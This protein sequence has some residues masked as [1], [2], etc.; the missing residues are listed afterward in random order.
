MEP[1]VVGV[2]Y[3]VYFALAFAGEGLKS[4]PL[5]LIGTA[6]YFV[7]AIA[8][9]LMLRPVEPAIAWALLPPAALGCVLQGVAILEKSRAVQRRS[10]AVFGLFLFVIGYLVLRSTFLPSAVG[11]ALTVGGLASCALIIPRLPTPALAVAGL[12]GILA[13][14]SLAVSLIFA[15]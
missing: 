7:L 3:V 8:L 6:W 14:G 9:C 10:F 1:H 15:S 12:L 13:E 5:K 11:V 2:A 4:T